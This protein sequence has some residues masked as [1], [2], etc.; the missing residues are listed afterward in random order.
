MPTIFKEERLRRQK[1][2]K[3]V[4]DKIR[5]VSKNPIVLSL[6][7]HKPVSELVSHSRQWQPSACQALL[8]LPP[9]RLRRDLRSADLLVQ[10]ARWR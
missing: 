6:S 4:T 3:Q 7:Q 9:V 2:H 5:N 8:D 1:T 10:I